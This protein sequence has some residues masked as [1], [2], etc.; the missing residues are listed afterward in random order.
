M[1]RVEGLQRFYFLAQELG[2]T[3]SS[4]PLEFIHILTEAKH[5][6]NEAMLDIYRRAKAEADY[7]AT[8]FLRMVLE[9]G[10][11][12]TAQY[13]LRA[14]TVSDGYTALWERNRLD[15]TVEAM[16]LRSE[17]RGLFSDVDRQIAVKRLRE[18]GYSGSL[19]DIAPAEAVPSMTGHDRGISHG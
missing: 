12:E 6:F 14:S 3:S 1:G 18:Y 8:R 19:P 16:I 4:K 17:W 2:L 15:L 11:L 10:G 5:Q 9:R 13:L 7:N